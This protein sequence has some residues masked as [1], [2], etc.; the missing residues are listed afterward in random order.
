M[1]MA[2]SDRVACASYVSTESYVIGALVLGWSLEHSGWPYE[3]RLL[4][5]NDVGDTSRERLARFWHR[6]VDVDPITNPHP[7]EERG[8]ETAS[9]CYTK[10]RVWQQTDLAKLVYLDSDTI[11]LGSLEALLDR[12]SFA[13]APCMWPSDRFNAGVLVL[14]PSEETFRSMAPLIGES[15]SYDGSDQGFLN[16]YFAD[17]FTG[18]AEHRLPVRYNASYFLYL[19]GPAWSDML[20][21]IRVLHYVGPYK[22]WHQSNRS[23]RGLFQRLLIRFGRA[24]AGL[25]SPHDLWWQ[26]HSTLPE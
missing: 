16:T 21:D 10:L 14:D 24:P 20:S 1:N 7:T 3:T 11:V 2:V 19:Y 13:A 12:P 8:L 6:I 23:L 18:P 22:P 17:W 26:L 25:P 5:T 4:V 15:P 9:E